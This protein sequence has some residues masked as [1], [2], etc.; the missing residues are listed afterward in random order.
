[1]NMNVIKTAIAIFGLNL[2]ENLLILLFFG[3]PLDKNAFIS[4]L[5][6]TLTLTALL[7]HL[8][9]LKKTQET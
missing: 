9:V 5:L 3:V 1:M 4:V 8:K 6:F 7:N 2:V